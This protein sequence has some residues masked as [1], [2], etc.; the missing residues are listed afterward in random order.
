MCLLVLLFLGIPISNEYG[1]GEHSIEFPAGVTEATITLWGGGGAGADDSSLAGGGAG[2]G[3]GCATSVVSVSSLAS[4]VLIVG[5]GGVAPSG[6]GTDSA[7]GGGTFV[8]VARGGVGANA[9]RGARGGGVLSPFNVGDVTFAG[10]SGGA[11]HSS[12]NGG[13][14]GGSAG[15]VGTGGNG[16]PGSSLSGGVGGTGEGDGGKGN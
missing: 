8:V 14:G 4:Y 11:G 1:P 5:D 2:G 12:G 7:F 13:G 3:S 6:D 9:R 15:I 16:S 10:G